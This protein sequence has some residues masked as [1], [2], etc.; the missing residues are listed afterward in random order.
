MPFLIH[1]SC[2]YFSCS[3]PTAGL[4]AVRILHD[5]DVAG[6]KLVAKVDAKNKLLLDNYKEEE[7]ERN[8]GNEDSNEA[9]EKKEDDD[10]FEAI[11]QYLS[12]HRSEIENYE[13]TQ[14]KQKSNK[15][16]QTA[17]IEEDKRDLINR[18]IGKFRKTAE[19][20]EQKKEKE[21]DRRKREEKERIRG[22]PS[23][24]KDKDKKGSSTSSRRRSRSRERSKVKPIE[25]FSEMFNPNAMA[26]I[27]FLFYFLLS[28]G[29]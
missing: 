23:P 12:D 1:V 3:G 22:S 10:V 15:M 6:K 17:V 26:L 21:K 16:L 9:H 29:A 14:G 5:L 4:R 25:K 19:A 24:R 8:K 28:V 27:K 11:Q 20:D 13:S 18:E 2:L 7:E